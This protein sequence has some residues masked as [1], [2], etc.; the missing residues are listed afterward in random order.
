MGHNWPAYTIKIVRIACTGDAYSI[1][2]ILITSQWLPNHLLGYCLMPSQPERMVSNMTLDLQIQ[3]CIKICLSNQ[4]E[5]THHHEVALEVNFH[6]LIGILIK[7]VQALTTSFE[8]CT[9]LE[10]PHHMHIGDQ[11]NCWESCLKPLQLKVKLSM[12][13]GKKPAG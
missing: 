2:G 12:N 4:S 10:Y 7:R 5:H 9:F 1:S 13:L 8:F 11:T 6:H 3:K